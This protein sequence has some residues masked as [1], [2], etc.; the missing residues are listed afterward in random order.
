MPY[1]TT[2]EVKEK[3]DLIKKEFP[4]F[5]FSITR[6]HYTSL[7]IAIMEGDMDLM[8]DSKRDYESVNHFHVESNYKDRPEVK[9]VLKKLVGIALN[10]QREIT[11]DDDYGS[12]PNFYINVTIGKWD[13][14]YTLKK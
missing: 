7:N 1:I 11:Y 3:R 2:E 8:G 13:K 5:K 6:Q 4:N 10:G 12:V 9:E 14:P